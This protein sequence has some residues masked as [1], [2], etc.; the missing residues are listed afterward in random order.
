MIVLLFSEAIFADDKNLNVIQSHTQRN[1]IEL[2]AGL[3]KPP[4]IIEKDSSGIE[5]DIFRAVFSN[6]NKETSFIHVP[7]GRTVTDFKRLNAD[8]IVTVLPDYQHP[9]LFVSKPYITYQNVAVSLLDN[10]FEIEDIKSL[11]GKSMIAF[12]N[13]RKYLGADF[14]KVISSAIVYREVA[15]QMKQINMLFLR[16]TEVIIL[17]INIFKYFLKVN[18]TGRY[19]Q[20]FKIHYIFNKRPYSAAFKSESNRNLFDL[21]IKELKEQG[22]YQLIMDK[23][24]K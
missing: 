12:Q 2:M 21:G 7:F 3:E 11:S 16:R 17:D 10:Q 8:G 13:A 19:E 1:Q 15:D 9:S 22:R 14:N 23:Y 5:L 6:A 20:P 18:K 4:F 24:I